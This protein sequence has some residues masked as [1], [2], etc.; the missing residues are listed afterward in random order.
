MAHAIKTV[1]GAQK[2]A[3]A[4]ILEIGDSH[5]NI[6]VVT[7]TVSR[8]GLGYVNRVVGD[9]AIKMETTTDTQ[10][11]CVVLKTRS[12]SVWVCPTTTLR[13]FPTMV[14]K[15][16][17]STADTIVVGV[18]RSLQ[19]QIIGIASPKDRG[20]RRPQHIGQILGNAAGET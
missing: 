18:I 13:D 3:D 6:H 16:S 5:A 15:M 7:I 10:P 4:L 14:D 8:I 2:G 11:R 19:H 1:F 17:R 20:W 12:L 9:V